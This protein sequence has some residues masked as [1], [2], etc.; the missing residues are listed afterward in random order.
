MLLC[1]FLLF[2]TNLRSEL[3]FLSKGIPFQYHTDKSPHLT[4][5]VTVLVVFASFVND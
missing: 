3:S 1:E 4:N 2:L 5:D